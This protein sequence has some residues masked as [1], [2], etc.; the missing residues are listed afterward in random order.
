MKSHELLRSSSL[1]NP[2]SEEEKTI[3]DDA[4][5]NA[6]SDADRTYSVEEDVEDHEDN[7][8][9]EEV[10]PD[11]SSDNASEIHEEL[12]DWLNSFFSKFA[13]F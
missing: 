1:Y 9:G 5:K 13:N 11:Y 3:G 8:D 7:K 12:D 2:E 10:E 4:A 6:D